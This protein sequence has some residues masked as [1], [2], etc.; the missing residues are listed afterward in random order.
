MDVKDEARDV[1]LDHLE[2]RQKLEEEKSDLQQKALQDLR[3]DLQR[4]ADTV[5]R[6]SKNRSRFNEAIGRW[7]ERILW[8]L[9]AALVGAWEYLLKVKGN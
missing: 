6:D 2:R 4:L 7:V 1:R 5:D 3:S 9:L 8:A